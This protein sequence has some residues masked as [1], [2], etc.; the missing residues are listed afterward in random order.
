MFTT[1]CV[2]ICDCAGTGDSIALTLLLL[3]IS[4]NEFKVEVKTV[5]DVDG[6]EIGIDIGDEEDNADD[7]V[8]MTEIVLV[9]AH[10]ADDAIG[11]QATVLV[12]VVTFEVKALVTALLLN[13]LANKLLMRVDVFDVVMLGVDDDADVVLLLVIFR[14]ILDELLESLLLL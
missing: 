8:V 5:V 6:Q 9:F 4:F 3:L 2:G 13:L 11:L 12:L 14:L 1:I 10:E 7:R